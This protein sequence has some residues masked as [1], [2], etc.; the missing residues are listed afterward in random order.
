ML[1]FVERF[2]K[3]RL[4]GAENVSPEHLEHIL[5]QLV[6]QFD[7]AAIL[8][9]LLVD[10][11]K[12]RE[13]AN[14]SFFHENGFSKIVLVDPP[15]QSYRLRL[16]LWNDDSDDSNIHNH[17]WNYASVALQGTI[18][19]TLYEECASGKP[20]FCYKSGQGVTSGCRTTQFKRKTQLCAIKE[21]VLNSGEIY[22]QHSNDVH[23]IDP[24][25]NYPATLVLQGPKKNHSVKI[26]SQSKLG[27]LSKPDSMSI[28]TLFEKL[29]EF[30]FINRSHAKARPLIN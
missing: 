2:L 19:S 5:E 24:I 28:D 16:H 26:Y 21:R 13:L 20:Y 7:M 6:D 30:G 17:K 14:R 11:R 9:Q 1:L 8:G 23:D 29:A 15:A 3:D 4:E 10:D 25:G 12:A 27:R 18:I 22:S